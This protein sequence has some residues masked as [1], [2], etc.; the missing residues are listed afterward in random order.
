MNMQS[1]KCVVVGDGAVGKTCLLISYTTNAF[2]GEY[3]PT[4]FDNYS[5]S[6]LVDGRPVSLG[7]WDTA[8]Q[9]DYDRLRPLSYPQTDVFLVCF[10]VVSPPSFENI[11]T[12]IPEIAHHA[13]GVPIILVGTKLDLREDPVTL[14][15][16]K[17]RRFS[18]ITY[19]MGAQC[20]R[21][22]GAVKYLEASSKTQKGL[23]NVFDEAIRA[24]LQ[25]SIGPMNPGGSKKK[26]KQCVIL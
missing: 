1:I 2:P 12:W 6:V 3:V 24:V 21:D 5:A 22:V 18:P 11:R 25:P 8:G 19:Q 4:V 14:Q 15:R 7:L 9:E 13:P 10:S 26:K 16:L 17:E 23:K 20:A